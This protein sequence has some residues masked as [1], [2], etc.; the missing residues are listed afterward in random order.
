MP[1]KLSDLNIVQGT[2][3]LVEAG[4]AVDGVKTE[5]EDED[6]TKQKTGDDQ[7]ET[8]VMTDTYENVDDTPNLRTCIVNTQQDTSKFETITVDIL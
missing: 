8:K 3:I 7:A 2:S 5:G 4:G 1:N 6:F